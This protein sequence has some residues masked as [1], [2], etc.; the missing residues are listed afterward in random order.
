MTGSGGITRLDGRRTMTAE[1]DLPGHGWFSVDLAHLIADLR[2]ERPRA[3]VR[4]MAR[5]D[6]APSASSGRVPESDIVAVWGRPSPA[7]HPAG[8]VVPFA[9]P[10]SASRPTAREVVLAVLLGLGLVGLALQNWPARPAVVVPVSLDARVVV[11]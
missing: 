1:A 6:P 7:P 8:E 4:A 10:N 2:A 5:P 11:T 3:A 9:A